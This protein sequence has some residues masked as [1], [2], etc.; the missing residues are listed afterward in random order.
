[1]LRLFLQ[2]VL[3]GG[4]LIFTYFVPL[5]YSKGSFSN[6]LPPYVIWTPIVFTFAGLLIVGFFSKHRILE[7]M[8]GGA[9]ILYLVT[10]SD[11][12]SSFHYFSPFAAGPLTSLLILAFLIVAAVKNPDRWRGLLAKMQISRSFFFYLS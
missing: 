6:P 8:V 1:M 2:S 5:I 4:I 9:V 3:A 12:S 10:F 7:T 11:S